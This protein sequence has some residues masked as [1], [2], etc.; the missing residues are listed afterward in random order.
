MP[1]FTPHDSRWPTF[2][3][4]LAGPEGCDFRDGPEGHPTWECGGGLDLSRSERILKK[5]GI[6]PRDVQMT[7]AWFR[8]H[9]VQCDCEVV[10]ETDRLLGGSHE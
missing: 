10:L 7:I 9:D 6:Q 2:M 1:P 5:M 4:R 8:G 3:E